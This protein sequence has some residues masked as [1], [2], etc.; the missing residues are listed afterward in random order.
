MQHPTSR[1]RPAHTARRRRGRRRDAGDPAGPTPAAAAPDQPTGSSSTP[2]RRPS[3]ACRESVLLGVSYLESRWDT[4]AG[5]PSTSG[6]YGP[7]HLTDAAHV[8]APARRTGQHDDQDEDPRGDESRPAWRSEP[9]EPTGP[10]APDGAAGLAHRLAADASTPP[11]RSPGTAQELLRTDPAANIR[12][13]AAL[14]AS[15]QRDTGRTDRGRRATRRPGT[16]RWPGTPA[17]TTRTPRR[18]SPTRCTTRSAPGASRLTDDGQRVTL[19]GAPGI[20]PARS[21]L[22]RLGLRKLT[23]PDGLECPP[24]HL[25]RVDPGAVRAFGDR[26]TTATTTSPTGPRGRRSSTSS[27][28]TPRAS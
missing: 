22:D 4:N 2:P 7:M 3:T 11:P 24:R 14:L 15:Y 5:T 26:A 27:S 8:A 6:G 19:T 1:R 18:P 25:L 9:V 20:S 28:T 21:W 10:T 17:R 23:R 12:G 13:G 16:A